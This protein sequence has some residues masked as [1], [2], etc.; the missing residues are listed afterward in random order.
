[1]LKR[2]LRDIDFA[3][4]ALTSCLVFFAVSG[5][6]YSPASHDYVAYVRQWGAMLQGDNPWAARSAYGPVHDAMAVAFYVDA[7]LPR[8]IFVLC[9]LAASLGIIALG[10]AN[11]DLPAGL[12]S[13]LCI[14][15]CFSIPCFGSL[16][17]TSAPTT[18]T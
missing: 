11:R 18:S 17:F 5:A 6:I 14:A 10:K 8:L 15:S 12:P 7:K 13:C 2:K 3:F 16:F 1:M 9:W 4:Y